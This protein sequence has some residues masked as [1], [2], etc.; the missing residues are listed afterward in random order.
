MLY[1]LHPVDQG[2]HRLRELSDLLGHALDQRFDIDHTF[3]VPGTPVTGKTQ[4]GRHR[5]ATVGMAL[6]ERLSASYGTQ[7]CLSHRDLGKPVV[8]R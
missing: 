7:V 8:E 4:R 2:L 1:V 6:S 3:S 5:A